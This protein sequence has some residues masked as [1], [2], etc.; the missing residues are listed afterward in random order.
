MHSF[1][2]SIA[3]YTVQAT[4][5]NAALGRGGPNDKQFNIIKGMLQSLGV[6][7]DAGDVVF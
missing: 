6:P 1:R 3:P 5:L 4:H 7:N 2:F